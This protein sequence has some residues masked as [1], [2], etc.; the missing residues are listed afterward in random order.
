MPST[1][2]QFKPGQ[3]GNPGG[4]PKGERRVRELAQQNT[5]EALDALVHV[6]RTG[7]PSERVAAANAILDRGWGRPMQAVN[8]DTTLRMSLVDLLASMQMADADPPLI[9]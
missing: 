4:R 2:S 9:E 8:V 7:R 3:S 1:Q 6:M 5:I